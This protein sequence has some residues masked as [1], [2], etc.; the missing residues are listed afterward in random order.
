MGLAGEQGPVNRWL[1]LRC[2]WSLVA[3][4]LLLRLWQLQVVDHSYWKARGE[5]IRLWSEPLAARRGRILDRHGVVLADNQPWIQGAVMTPRLQAQLAE[6]Q[7]LGQAEGGL[8]AQRVYPFKNLFSH[9]LGY[10]TEVHP[11]SGDWKGC[12]GLELSLE[13]DLKGEDGFR[14]W[15]M[16][17]QGQ[18]LR[19]VDEQLPVAG[20]DQVTTLDAELQLRAHGYLASVLGQLGSVRKASD[21]PAGA[22]VVVEA[23]T[24][25]VLSLVSMPDYNPNAFLDPAAERE[26]RRLLTSSESP[27]LNRALC[28]LYPA[29]STFKIVTASAS[30]EEGVV[31]PESS[32]HCSGLTMVGETP[33][34]C[35]V[36]RG[37][38]QLTFE[39]ALAHS[40]DCV[41][42]ELGLSLGA[43]RLESWARRWG[44][45]QPCGLQLPGEESGWLPPSPQPAGEV[46]NFSIGQGQL[47][48]TP[49][50]MAR[51]AAGVANRGRIPGLTLL[52]SQPKRDLEV[53]LQDSTWKV[54]LAG[55]EGAVSR[56]TAASAAVGS[57]LRLA[58]KTGTVENS[59]SDSNPRGYNHTWFVA[60][61]PLDSSNPLAIAV[62]LERS[63]GYGGALAA[64]VAIRLLED[65]QKIEEKSSRR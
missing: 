64:P 22:V 17:A 33:F 38:G 34:H 28:G 59:P 1:A 7:E 47:L 37:H 20:M 14:Q 13:P 35:F 56:G 12:D 10:V 4:V 62:F 16:T 9:L 52:A 43:E 36:R 8:T 25:E 30:L 53:K 23:K 39:D 41:F 29:A 48:V 45:G 61:G 18:P 32:F 50:Q 65:W 2:L 21:Q 58:G 15:L 26:R 63:G 27:L 11:G 57:R 31:K 3:L 44:L 60:V 42:Y 19:L 54:L 40:C 49:L 46:A 51:L 24:G 6:S 5:Q 55:L